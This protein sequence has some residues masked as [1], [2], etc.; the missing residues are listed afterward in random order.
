MRLHPTRLLLLAGI[1]ACAS[2]A[3]HSATVADLAWLQGCWRDG[4]TS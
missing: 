2:M 1:V 4:V 3:A